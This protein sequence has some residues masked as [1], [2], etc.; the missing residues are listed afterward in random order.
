MN[1]GIIGGGVSGLTCAWILSQDHEVTLYEQAGYAGGHTNTVSVPMAGRTYNVDTGFIVFNSLNYPLFSKLLGQLEVESRETLMTFSVRDDRRGLE[2]CGTGL[3]GLFAQKRNLFSPSF[4]GMI[5][6]I[7]RFN[8]AAKA[9]AE[10]GSSEQTLK[11]FVDGLK[12]GDA[13]W[14][15]YLVPM[16]SAIW[17]MRPADIAGFP[18]FFLA[19]FMSNHRMLQVSG[20]PIWRTING[21]SWSY[22][23]AMSQRI[24][25]YLRLGAKVTSINRNQ[26]G[27]RVE[28]S[29]GEGHHDSVIF[30]CHSDQA[31]AILGEGATLA[32][33]EILSD[34]PYQPNEAIL[35]T[36]DSLMPR[37]KNAWAA[38]NAHVD[39]EADGQATVTYNLN[40]LQGHTSPAPFMVSLGRGESIDPSKIIR[41]IQYAHPAYQLNS[42]GAQARWSE[43]SNQNSRTHFCGAY[44]GY[45]FHEDGVKSAVRVCSSLGVD[46]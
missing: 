28:S 7:M 17:S 27:V 44:W 38:W 25:P 11:Q 5:R 20:R 4:H 31:L 30:A 15:H 32:E 16:S 13:F 14:D 1:I 43:I 26:G 24:R 36:D 37:K 33:R 39:K 10:S 35:H 2:Y 45:G 29:L 42:P 19:K 21:G 22:V 8:R 12:L 46:W 9:L 23:R 18:A 3:S 41:R 40:I 34:I 6:D